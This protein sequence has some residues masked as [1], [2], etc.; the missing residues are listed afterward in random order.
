MNRYAGKVRIGVIAIFCAAALAI[1]G[2]HGSPGRAQTTPSPTQTPAGPALFVTDGCS[3]AVTAYPAASNGDVSPLAPAPTGLSIPAFVAVDASGNIYITNICNATIS[4]YAKGSSGDAAPIAIIGGS[5]TGLTDPEGI[6]LDS[7][8]NIYVTDQFFAGQHAGAVLVYAAGSNGNVAPI[9]TI[10]GTNTDL[11]NPAGIALD[12]SGNIYVTNEDLNSVFVYAALGSST[13]TLNEAPIVTIS[14]SNTGLT[15][16][17]GI[18]LDSSGNIYVA[19]DGSY[20]NEFTASVFVYPPLGSSTGTLDEA[21]IAT[22]SGSDTGLVSPRGIGLDSIGNIYVVNGAGV[23]VYPPLGSSTGLLN[24]AP[25]ATIS[26]GDTGLVNPQGIALD[27]SGKIYVADE[28]AASVFVFSALGSS[29][30]LLD[31]AAIATISTT[32]T[33]GLVSPRGI[34]LDS[35]GNIYVADD[36]SYANEYTASVFVY[37]AGSNGNVAPIASISGSSTRLV[38]PAGIALDY[39]GNIYVADDGYLSAPVPIPS[40]VF[41]YAAGSNGNVAPIATIRGPDTGL[42]SPEGVTLDSK[43]NIYV[44]DADAASVFVYRAGSNGDAAPIA[45]ISGSN[46]GLSY[47][48]G[49]ALDSS[50]NIYVTGEIAASVFVYSALGSSTGL[51]NEAPIATISGSNTGLDFPQGIAVD[52][53]G[54]IY[55]A[56]RGDSSAFPPIPPTVLV[57]PPGSNG[58]ETPTATISGPHTELGSPLFIAIQPV[59]GATT[60]L[61]AAPAAIKFGSVDATGTSKPEKVTLTNKGTTAAVIGSVTATPPFVV[62]GGE[63]TCSGQSIEPKKKCLVRGQV[64]AGHSRRREQCNDRGCL[65]RRQSRDEPQRHWNCRDAQRAVQGDVLV[66]RGRRHR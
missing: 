34:G 28:N 27:S 63:N 8:G 49:I 31:V 65:Q 10:G 37:P 40:K 64:C 24:E 66:S 42:Y 14:G 44:A 50:G 41:V 11:T 35:I 2:L 59:A 61:A 32:M 3:R 33:T 58:N 29:T 17:Y 7:S 57:Y 6:A 54:N 12:S 62:A 13:G 39:G 4:I 56:D 38:E 25:T 23:S 51:L 21:P 5:N 55:V 30:G 20:A 48:Y 52:S 36:G 43:G 18:A 16:P 19:D 22:I 9:L 45:T 53:S 1:A 26:G 60:T 46:T 47:P 15:N